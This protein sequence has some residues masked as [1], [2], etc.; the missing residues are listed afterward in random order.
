MLAVFFVFCRIFLFD[1][2]GNPNKK[3][4]RNETVLHCVCAGGIADK[5][6]PQKL[7]RGECILLCL[8][9]KGTRLPNGTVECINLAATD[10]VI[11]DQHTIVIIFHF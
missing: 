6:L 3:N 2:G 1:L 7:R 8:Q 4:A 10:E 9:W 11:C 5:S